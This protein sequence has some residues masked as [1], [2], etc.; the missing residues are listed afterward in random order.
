MSDGGGGIGGTIGANV[1]PS[2]ANP[3]TFVFLNGNSGIG[4]STRQNNSATNANVGYGGGGSDASTSYGSATGGSGGAGAYINI[5]YNGNVVPF[6]NVLTYIIGNSGSGG[7]TN[8][9]TGGIK[10]TW[11]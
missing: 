7:G 4:G 5:T 11:T 10:I 9:G 8:G 6:G 2:I 3:K 1:S